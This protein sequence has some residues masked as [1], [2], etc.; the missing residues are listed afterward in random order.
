M[1]TSR[2]IR[3]LSIARARATVAIPS[4]YNV[5]TD[6]MWTVERNWSTTDAYLKG[7]RQ[8]PNIFELFEEAGVDIF[9]AKVEKNRFADTVSK[10]VKKLKLPQFPDDAQ[11]EDD[12]A[13]GD[14]LDEVDDEGENQQELPDPIPPP[15]IDPPAE[16]NGEPTITSEEQSGCLI[17]CLLRILYASWLGMWGR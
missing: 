5:T 6:G 11:V 1:K 9:D 8:G 3:A 15:P 4:D 13:E 16:G 12:E 14:N 17:G 7:R 10:V 2:H